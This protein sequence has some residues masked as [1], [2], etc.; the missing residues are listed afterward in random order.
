MNSYTSALITSTVGR[1]A[2]SSGSWSGIFSQT[3]QKMWGLIT[4]VILPII[5]VALGVSLVITIIRAA[6]RYQ[7]SQTFNPTG[8]IVAGAAFVFVIVMRGNGD[9]APLKALMGLSW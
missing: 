7:E 6:K 3:M 4:D 2:F 9:G 8:I 5:I 1:V